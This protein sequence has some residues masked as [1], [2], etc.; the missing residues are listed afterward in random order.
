MSF[1]NAEER[2]WAGEKR[3]FVADSRDDAADER[4]IAAD[5]RDVVASAR[6]A[7]ADAR[8]AE[9]NKRDEQL[10][11]RASESGLAA[12][13]GTP[14]AEPGEGHAREVANEER[15][16]V[17]REREEDKVSR[18][19]ATERRELEDRPTLLALAFASIAERLYDADT[20]D[21]ALTRIATAAVATIAGGQWAS[22]TLSEKNTYRTAAS[23]DEAATAVDR[24]QYEAGEGPSLDALTS[25]LV[26]APG[27]PDVRWPILGA[28]PSEHG[29]HSSLSYQLDTHGRTG[30]E[31]QRG[32]LNVYGLTPDAFDQTAHE[33][34]TIL[35]AH[36]SLAAR[37]VGERASLEALDHHLEQAL[38]SRDV[39]G[40]A[41]GILM[42]RL[43]T[44]PDEAF[45]I[46]KRSSQ[47][48]NVKLREVARKLAETGEV[49]PDTSK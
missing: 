33:I 16:D 4:D 42:E 6:E 11:A 35:A 1:S 27:F 44:T 31:T 47:R 12:G 45:D 26:D 46:L 36:A 34:G 3:E 17:G 2:A 19:A 39:I 40:Q 8:E 37:A 20:Y 21:E 28:H 5:A 13:R 24:E 7:I 15:S 10:R 48:L 32:S 29:V 38:L 9:L 30:H 25:A 22:V 49:D 14:A 41:K 43:K 18:D 23:T